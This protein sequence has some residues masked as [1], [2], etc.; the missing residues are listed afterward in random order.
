MT[1]LRSTIRPKAGIFFRKR[2]KTFHVIDI[3]AGG[4]EVDA[5]AGLRGVTESGR[6]N[7]LRTP[8]NLIEKSGA[9]RLKGEKDIASVDGGGNDDVGSREA[10]GDIEED[11]CMELRAIAAHENDGPG[12]KIG[13]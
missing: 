5:E 10:G 7:T 2:Q 13:T 12:G 9:I 6:K 8:W 11:V 4:G 3:D 1:E